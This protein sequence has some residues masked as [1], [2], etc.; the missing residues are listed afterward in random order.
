MFQKA[1]ITNIVIYI[2]IY[3]YIRTNSQLLRKPPVAKV[4]K[5]CISNPGTMKA[6]TI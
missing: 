4:Y 1:L 3:I 5:S 2:Y 6:A